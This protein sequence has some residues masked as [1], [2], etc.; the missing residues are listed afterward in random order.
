MKIESIKCQ[1]KQLLPTLASVYLPTLC[2]L[3]S[4]VLLSL[5]T[6][7]NLSYIT[8][9]P[10]AIANTLLN[11]V[12]LKPL[13]FPVYIGVVSNL[14]ILLWCATAATCFFSYMLL[15]KKLRGK[16]SATFFLWSGGISTILLFDDLFLLHEEVIP[17]YLGIS[18]LIVFVGYLLIF[19]L[20]FTRW[21]RQILQTDYLL[22]LL[23][24]IFFSF[25]ILI[26][27]SSIS[28]N[29]DTFTFIEDSFK[30]FGI[31]SWSTY[32]IRT[33]FQ[34][35]NIVTTRLGLQK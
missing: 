22:L 19:V 26:D 15:S 27:R 7:T 12:P 10:H 6:N 11:L 17:I 9:D 34:D 13:Y 2:F 24:L 1:F 16:P 29:Q 35:I 18:E 30:F 32:Y 21:R 28:I 20:Y 33:C 31:V 14:G 3:G 25:S 5:L 23:A 8:R 4:L